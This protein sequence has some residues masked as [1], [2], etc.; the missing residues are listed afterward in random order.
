V[1]S[2]ALTD[3]ETGAVIVRAPWCGTPQAK[4][5]S[6]CPVLE[7]TQCTVANDN[8]FTAA[9]VYVTGPRAQRIP[10]LTYN[11]RAKVTSASVGPWDLSAG[12]SLGL[13][14]DSNMPLLTITLRRNTRGTGPTN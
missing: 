2:I 13:I 1:I 12:G 5:V 10:R 6:H 11:A 9:S 4:G 7:G 3:R 8:L 14:V